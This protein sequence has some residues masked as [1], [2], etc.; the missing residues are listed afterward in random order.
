VDRLDGRHV[1]LTGASRGIGA[2][3]AVRLGA[4]GAV[5]SLAARD[6]AALREVAERVVAAGGRAVVLPVDLSDLEAATALASRAIAEAGPVDVVVHNAGIEPFAAFETCDPVAIERAIAVNVTAP[7]RLTRA[8]LPDM[9]ARGAGHVVFV[10]STSGLFATP[11]AAT[12]SATKAAIAAASRSLAIEYADRGIRTSVVQPGFVV[13]TGMFED[14]RVGRD[15]RPP[16]FTGST[17]TEAV[18]DAIIGA[19]VYER[20]DV[21]VNSVP[22]SASIALTRLSPRLGIWA[23][24]KLVA[25]FMA[26]LSGAR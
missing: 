1:L 22:M 13:G 26:R 23:M 5:V 19:I 16:R 14:A 18:V 11:Y 6:E 8:L 10:G 3:L 7:L 20:P 12:Y 21:I 4:E 25:P 24:S 17:T 9:L 2:A 15:L